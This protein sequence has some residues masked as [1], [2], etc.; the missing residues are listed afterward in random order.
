MSPGE[1]GKP[2][3]GRDLRFHLGRFTAAQFAVYPGEKLFVRDRH[4]SFAGSAVRPRT[5]L[6]DTAGTQPPRSLP[7]AE[8][9][10]PRDICATPVAL[11]NESKLGFGPSNLMLTKSRITLV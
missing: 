1:L 5:S 8:G 3:I 7:L 11:E 10:D 9:F 4:D 6:L 2:R